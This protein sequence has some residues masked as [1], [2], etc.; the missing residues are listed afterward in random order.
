MVSAAPG[1][2]RGLS[3]SAIG[4][5]A[6][7]VLLAWG[8]IALSIRGEYRRAS[9]GAFRDTANMV[10]TVEAQIAGRFEA[11]D[12]RLRFAQAL[13]ERDPDGFRFGAWSGIDPA[14]DIPA[15]FVVGLD[16]VARI[17]A[18]GPVDDGIDR[19]GRDYMRAHLGAP[20]EDRLHISA[21]IR[22]RSVDRSLLV[23]SRP[24]RR[25]GVLV[26]VVLLGVDAWSFS[27][28]YLSL[29]IGQGVISLVG[30][31][32]IVR[33]WVPNP[34]EV[35]GRQ[36]PQPQAASILAGTPQ[37]SQRMASVVDGVDRFTTLRRVAGQDM[38]VAVGLPAEAVLAPVWAGAWRQAVFGG[39]LSLL[40][41]AVSAMLA[42]KRRAAGQARA[43]LEAAVGHIGQGILMV[44][45]AGRVALVNARAIELL[46][47]PAG[48]AV[49][50]RPL[51]DIIA[52]QAAAGEFGDAPPPE[53]RYGSLSAAP[54]APPDLHERVRP[55][56][57]V[58]EIR[59]E[60]LADGSHV[61]TYTD[62]TAPRRAAESIAEARD[63]A[64]AAEAALAA[65]IENVPHGVLMVDAD[66]RVVVLTRR[67][68]EMLE[69]PEELGRPGTDV[70]ALFHA[71]VAR[72]DLAQ[73]PDIGDGTR[74]AL[75]ERPAVI[76]TYERALRNG[77]VI[78]VRSTVLA[79]GRAVR[80]YTDVTERRAA[81][82]AQETARLAAE[83]NAR[84]RTEFLAMV[85][86]E[87]RTPLN[88]VIGLSGL[89]LDQGLPEAQAQ[90]LRLIREAGDHLLALVN[91][92]LDVTRL[93]RGHLPLQEAP[94]DPRQT[95]GAA[96]QLM[97]RQAEEKGLTLAFAVAEAVPARLVGDAARLR[98][99]L[100][101]LL[102]N[103]VKFTDAGGIEVTLTLLP[104]TQ[105][106]MVRL[107]LAVA[108]SGIGIAPEAQARLFDVFVQGDSG[109]ARRFAGAGLGLAIC[110]MLLDRM[111][112]S[113]AVESAAG[114]GSTFRCTLPLRR[115]APAEAAAAGRPLR[116]L[117][118]EDI[119]ANRL[120]ITHNLKRLGH[121]VEA[122]ANGAEAV[123][124]V[125][126]SADAPFDLVVMDVMMPVMDGLAAT[127][128]IRALPGPAGR[129]PVIALTAH[130]SP[131]AAAECYAA[132][133]DRFETKP[134][135]PDALRA[136]I[137]AVLEARG[138]G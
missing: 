62:L 136:A 113:I 15:G 90:H 74:M 116:V 124:A 83:Q 65:T 63:R 7:V 56:G 95:F 98:Q 6:A 106:G 129:I 67:A 37:L 99:V 132:G 115:A 25:D 93:E 130:G 51:R 33:A 46:G 1:G 138:A 96:V 105:E 108:D 114:A 43:V 86:H 107:G 72:G 22:A 41:G 10:R 97:R 27:R 73:V 77:R 76:P 123:A 55:N 13:H 48:L 82:Q 32:G 21:P 100:L 35:V 45:P 14:G 137:A 18:K 39:A 133:I 49:P 36:L 75:A 70:R 85:S 102:G 29:D 8:A 119:A 3:A 135:G 42:Q 54:G 17:G 16:G 94:F 131:E 24:L 80:T 118:A 69:L 12:A 109:A 103:A 64:V 117:V 128:A 2:R 28:L 34:E 122:A 61:R 38:L 4:V 68:L 112:G 79:D 59:T 120:L 101:N 40:V 111:G 60:H 47:L 9:D 44:D 104:E 125:K 26:G 20:G 110:R 87:L 81:A 50:G 11:I 57:T 66:N 134:I 71:Q 88:A 89:L 92:I 91:D 52:W 78:E 31:D 19:S 53:T 30:F 23:F 121:A 126:A 5:A 84:A 58:L 127:R